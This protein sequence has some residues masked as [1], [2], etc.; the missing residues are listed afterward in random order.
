MWINY[1][2]TWGLR[3]FSPKF[4]DGPSISRVPFNRPSSC[5]TDPGCDF[6]LLWAGEP[7]KEAATWTKRMFRHL[8]VFVN[9]LY[10]K[11]IGQV[12]IGI[13]EYMFARQ[14]MYDCGKT[15]AMFDWGQLLGNVVVTSTSSTRPCLW[16]IHR[17]SDSVEEKET[18]IRAVSNVFLALKSCYPAN[19]IHYQ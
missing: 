13:F 19:Y 18:Q 14:V 7:Q 11:K 12:K 8:E 9:L 6:M 17:P 1:R 15:V 4:S 2:S 5:C 3:W 16:K 10:P